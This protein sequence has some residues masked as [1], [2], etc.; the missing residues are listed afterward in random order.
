VFSTICAQIPVDRDFPVRARTLDILRRTLAG[1]LYDSLPYDFY[2]EQTSGGE[3]IPLRHR[4]PSVRYGLARI[5]VEDSVGLLFSESHFPTI[6]CSDPATRDAIAAVVRATK[7]NSVM[8]EAALRGSIGSS[9]IMLRILR[10]RPFLD[11]MDTVYLTPTWD[12]EA[13]DTLQYVTE[14]YKVTGAE[15]TDMGY[16]VDDPGAVFWFMRRWDA[17]CETRF[18]PKPVGAAG[19]PVEDLARSARHGL[20]FVPIVWIR[21]LPGGDGIDG[22]STFRAALETSIEIDYQLSQAGRGLRYS[23]APDNLQQRRMDNDGQSILPI[24]G[25]SNR[26]HNHR[27]GCDNVEHGIL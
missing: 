9:A 23:R 2:Q 6:E 27:R 13:P 24:R 18:V 22:A 3:Y 12:P 26:Q 20:G 8:I 7:L 4:R 17:E 15:L 11:V 21:N 1:T 10:G 16:D 5:V 25:R 19:R 14:R